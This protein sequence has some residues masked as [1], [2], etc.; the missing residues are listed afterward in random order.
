M[1]IL[2]TYHEKIKVCVEVTISINFSSSL[3]YFRNVLAQALAQLLKNENI[4]EAPSNCNTSGNLWETGK[5]FFEYIRKQ[6]LPDGLTGRV[7]F[8]GMGDRIYAEYEVINLQNDPR[9][10]FAREVNVGNYKYSKVR[11]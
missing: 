11:V 5:K 1:N 6:I 3:S 8:D 9:N 4:T 2:R 10:N 7:A